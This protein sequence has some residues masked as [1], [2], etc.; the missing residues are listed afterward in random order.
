MQISNLALDLTKKYGLEALNSTNASIETRKTYA[1]AWRGAQESM[2]LSLNASYEGKYVF[3]GGDGQNSPFSL[4]TGTDG[5]QI[6]RYRGVDVTD[7]DRALLDGYAK[8][9]LYVDLGFGLSVDPNNTVDP[10]SAF[11][12]SLPGINLVGYGKDGEDP[13]NMV[14]L[15][16]KIADLLEEEDFNREK[17]TELLDKF[18]AG[19]NSVLEQVTSL[20]TKTEFLTTTKERLQ[21]NEISLAT[22]IDH[23]VNVDMPEAIMNFSWAQYAYNASLKVGTTILS[24]SFIDFMK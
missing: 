4:E 22:Q 13:K 21:T 24:P 12:M 17:Y 7:G 3:A 1:A 16:G 19:R 5:R 20:G 10:S 23:V 14:L 18:E 9:T 11:N 6:L 15:A 8:D 2:L